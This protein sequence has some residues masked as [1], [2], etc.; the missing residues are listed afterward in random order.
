MTN[1]EPKFGDTQLHKWY[2]YSKLQIFLETER[3][4][5]KLHKSEIRFEFQDVRTFCL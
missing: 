1:V 5:C 2:F 4:R 3:P